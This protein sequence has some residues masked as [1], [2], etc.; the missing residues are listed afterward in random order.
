MYRLLI[1]YGNII[2]VFFYWKPFFNLFFIDVPASLLVIGQ[3][4]AGMNPTDC[5][6][7]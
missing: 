5:P 6:N 1:V 3:R 2:H 4:F 7:L